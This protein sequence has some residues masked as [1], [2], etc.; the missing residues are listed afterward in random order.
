MNQ[1]KNESIIWLRE[2]LHNLLRALEILAPPGEW[3]NGFRA[4]LVAVAIAT[5]IKEEESAVSNHRS[6]G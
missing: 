4:A 6:F 3:G 1:V 2:D 5:G